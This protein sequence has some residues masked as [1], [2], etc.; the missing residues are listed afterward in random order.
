[1]TTSRGWAD[2][3]GQVEGLDTGLRDLAEDIGEAGMRKVVS[4]FLETIG[5]AQAGLR[6]AW[7]ASDVA[8]LERSAHTLKAS[9]ALLGAGRIAEQCAW[10]ERHANDQVS[11]AVVDELERVI[12]DLCR[13]LESLAPSA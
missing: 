13:A 7:Q 2:L 4:L 10:I 9:V 1:M 11:Q 5:P 12:G 6:R 8:L 3:Q